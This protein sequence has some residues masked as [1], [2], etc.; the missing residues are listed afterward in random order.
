VTVVI[1]TF[2]QDWCKI[3]SLHV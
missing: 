2:Y 1:H 3:L